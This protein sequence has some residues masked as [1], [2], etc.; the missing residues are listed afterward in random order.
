MASDSA[1]GLG[2]QERNGCK[3]H[4]FL[5]EDIIKILLFFCHLMEFTLV[6]YSIN[7]SLRDL[8][9]VSGMNDNFA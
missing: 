3:L 1:M 9:G 2:L 7:C 5:E 6:S 4:L 8:T